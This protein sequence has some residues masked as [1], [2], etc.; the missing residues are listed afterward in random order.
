MKAIY[1]KFKKYM[2][3]EVAYYVTVCH[4]LR[5]KFYLLN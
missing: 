2:Y 4:Y 3:Y 5:I 1:Y